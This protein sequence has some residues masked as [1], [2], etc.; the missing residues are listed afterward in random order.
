MQFKDLL[1]S[2]RTLHR[3]GIDLLWQASDLGGKDAKFDISFYNM[4]THLACLDEL[5]HKWYQ[6]PCKALELEISNVYA[7]ALTERL[8]FRARFHLEKEKEKYE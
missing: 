6:L 1:Q 8:E 2:C 4:Q 7:W 3:E 5:I